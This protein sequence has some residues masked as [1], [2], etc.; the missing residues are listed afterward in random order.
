[1]LGFLSALL[2]T[3]ITRALPVPEPTPQPTAAE[4]LIQ[5]HGNTLRLRCEQ[6]GRDRSR[7]N[8]LF[9]LDRKIVTITTFK[10]GYLRRG[11]KIERYRHSF[12]EIKYLGLEVWMSG[13]IPAPASWVIVLR[14]VEGGYQYLTFL[15]EDYS[16]C[17]AA[18][19]CICEAAGIKRSDLN[20]PPSHKN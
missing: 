5:R 18:L 4:V 10:P 14:L 12:E 20:F 19:T 9:F 8:S 16:G 13:E 1:M 2:N 15:T 7:I 11:Y 17:E 6:H 3:L